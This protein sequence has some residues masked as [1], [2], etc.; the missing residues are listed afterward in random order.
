MSNAKKKRVSFRPSVTETRLEQRLVL[1]SGTG[2]TAVANPAVVEVIPSPVYAELS[3]TPPPAAPPVSAAVARAR[4]SHKL[5]V[6]QLRADY[7][8]QVRAAARDLRSAIKADIA[9]LYA[10]GSTPTAQQLADFKASAAGAVN[11][12]ALRLSTQAA[13]LPDSAR[14]VSAVQNEV[15]GSG[16]KSL[17]SRLVSLAQSGKLSGST[18]ASSVA[19]S[20]RRSTPPASRPS[21]RSTTTSTRP[22]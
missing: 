22:R 20:R 13:L 3:L 2:V 15:L 8:K 10:N 5:T 12:T 4:A 21:R 17:A 11:A 7:T 9:Q 6:R 19:P 14:L 16:A 18:A 1:S